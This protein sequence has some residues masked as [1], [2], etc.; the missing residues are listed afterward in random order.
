[1]IF[2]AC[3]EALKL[4]KMAVTFKHISFTGQIF[5]KGFKGDV[6]YL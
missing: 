4:Q 2:K 5:D 6:F 1:M 3:G